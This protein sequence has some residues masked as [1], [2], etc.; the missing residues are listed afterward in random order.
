[1]ASQA[2]L[3]GVGLH[4]GAAVRVVLTPAAGPIRFA[5]RGVTAS[6]AD[7]EVVSTARATTVATRDGALRIGTIEHALSALAGLGLRDGVLV[8]LDGP[9]LPL[10]D[11]GA[12]AYCDALRTL[13]LRPGTPTLRVVRE[14]SFDIGPSRFTFR[15]GDAL[16]VAV[17]VEL[18]PRFERDAR[19]LG[20]AEDYVHRI[21]PART[22][23]LSAEVEELVRR[24]LARHVDPAS[25]VVLTPDG[26]LSAGRRFAPDEPAR[27]KLL[28]L[29]G[30]LYL[31][32]GPPLGHVH[33]LR[34]GHAPNAR[35]LRRALAEG[36]LVPA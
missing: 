5:Q 28:D 17:T 6:L 29:L 27:H 1:M 14:A 16:D 8:D 9:E 26:V 7:L 12:A 19:W 11:G 34:P 33:A 35:A 18:D 21:A 25:V 31:H 10:L 20:D 24:G 2:V 13:P 30:D 3:E 36:V 4:S 32:G 22:F 15:P 23:T